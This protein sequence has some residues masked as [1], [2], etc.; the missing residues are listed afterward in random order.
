MKEHKV[1]TAKKAKKIIVQKAKELEDRYT[2]VS[3]E[4]DNAVREVKKYIENQVGQEEEESTEK[5]LEDL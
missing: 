2:V 3:R 4:I 5:L 1:K